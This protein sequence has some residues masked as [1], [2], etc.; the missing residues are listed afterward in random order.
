MKYDYT[1]AELEEWSRRITDLAGQYGLDCYHQEF[2][3]CDHQEMIGYMAY[4]GMPS[5][6]KHWSYGKAFEQTE[7]LY[8][9]GLSGLPYEMVI[10]SNPA[11]AFLMKNNSLALQLLTIAHVL[12]HN[13]FFKNNRNFRFTNAGE[14]LAR[15]RIHAQRI[16]RYLEHPAIGIDRVEQVLD[17]AHALAF[18]CRRDLAFPKLSDEEQRER[19]YDR[20]YKRPPEAY[21]QLAVSEKV[22]EEKLQRELQKVPLESD[23]DILL[24]I[25]DHNRRLSEWEKDLLTIVHEEAQYYIPQIK[26]KIMN[27]GWAS[28]WHHRLMIALGLG[29]AMHLEFI[30]HH[31]RVLRPFDPQS[32]NPYRVG[33]AIWNALR[34]YYDGKRNQNLLDQSRFEHTL[35]EAM[36]HDFKKRDMEPPD[37]G[38]EG[39]KGESK[40][41]EVRREA[42]DVSF[43][44]RFLTPPIMRELDLYAYVE[45]SDEE[46]EARSII[47]E[48]S[49][50]QHWKNIKRALINKV[51]M[52]SFPVIKVEDANHGSP[53]TLLLKHYHDGRDLE[54]DNAAKTLN[55]VKQLW[56]GKVTLETIM[57]E[58]AAMCYVDKN[59]ELRTE[60]VKKAVKS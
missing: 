40:I 14:T 8:R 59:G 4:S 12:G 27:E 10:N 26:T 53:G 54:K 47:S 57:D 2:Q 1:L 19:I 34:I 56:G 25:R 13:D 6:Y 32:I 30:G 24:F 3:I 17:A 5:H 18:Q 60:K 38:L 50:D 49:D 46:E 55:Y 36:D 39:K 15:T 58:E 51:G 22:D 33:W 23:E 16:G 42:S 41:F 7:T 45:I 37:A 48:V 43:I 9:Y 11:I 31:S 35:F 21:R 52:N 29:Q 28:Y 44:D 20:Y